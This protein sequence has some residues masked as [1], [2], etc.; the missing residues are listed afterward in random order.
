MEYIFLGQNSR[1]HNEIMRELS[2]DIAAYS[3]A[4]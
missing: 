4:W 2:V 3:A 1:P